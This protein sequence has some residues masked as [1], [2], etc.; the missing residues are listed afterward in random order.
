MRPREAGIPYQD[1][2]GRFA[3]FHSLRKTLGTNLAKAGVPRRTAMSVM[4]HSD[5]NL[6][7]KI[8][9]DENLLGVE[10][11]IDVLP[12]FIETP[13]QGASQKPVMGWHDLTPAVTV[14]ALNGVLRTIENKGESHDLA[15]ATMGCH[16]CPTSAHL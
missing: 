4:R 12:A 8:Y 11:A 15:L 1:A 3:D 7:D 10:T 14:P 2:L 16:E 9:T 6:T 5:G 13:S